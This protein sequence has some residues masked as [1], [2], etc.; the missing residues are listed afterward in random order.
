MVLKRY[1]INK[2]LNNNAITII[3]NGKDTIIQNG[4]DTIIMYPG[5]GFKNKVGNFISIKSEY[6]IYRLQNKSLIHKFE[7]LLNEIPYDCI[8]LTQKIISLAEDQLHKEFNNG[9]L[10]SLADHIYFAVINYQK[11]FNAGLSSEEIKRF[12]NEEYNVGLKA[13]DIIND[14]YQIH[15]NKVEA[16]SIAF[17][18]I[19]AEYT[20]TSEK[21]RIMLESIDKIVKIIEEKLN[22]KLEENTL[23]Y[24]KWKR[25]H[26]YVSRNRL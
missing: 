12:Y 25:Y 17:H 22:M 9:L 3:Q 16:S 13:I 24:S 1:K 10:L 18:I 11:G 26:Y 15:L 14:Y 7:I 6:N 21:T 4:K 23:N 8:E 2:I 5:I 20:H 19:N